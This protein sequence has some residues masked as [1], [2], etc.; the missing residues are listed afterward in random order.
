MICPYCESEFNVGWR[1]VD[2]E[3]GHMSGRL[4]E[5]TFVI[6]I[7]ALLFNLSLPLWTNLLIIGLFIIVIALELRII[8]RCPSCEE[9]I[10]A[11]IWDR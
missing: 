6:G 10:T 8:I 5:V 3:E 9:E 1:G 2:S 7:L 11:W 4:F